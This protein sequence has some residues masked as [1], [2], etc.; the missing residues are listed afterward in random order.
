MEEV[1]QLKTLCSTSIG[2]CLQWLI[3]STTNCGC[4]HQKQQ[5]RTTK[6]RHSLSARII[7]C[8]FDTA[9]QLVGPLKTHKSVDVLQDISTAWHCPQFLASLAEDHRTVPTLPQGSQ[10]EGTD[11]WWA[12]DSCHCAHW[13]GRHVREGGKEAW[14][15]ASTT[16]KVG[17]G[18]M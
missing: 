17:T 3:I 16:G 8:Q 13:L 12:S 9:M 2:T 15:R 14:H 1:K 10:Q 4:P 5:S 6:Q 11:T 7:P 18:G